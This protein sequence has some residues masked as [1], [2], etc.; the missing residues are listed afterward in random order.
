[1]KKVLIAIVILVVLI[2]AAVFLGKMFKSDGGTKVAAEEV[3]SRTIIETVTAN[4]TI[5][6]KTEVKISSEVSGE[7][8]ELLV[9]EGDSVNQGD[10]LLRINPDLS[11][12][13]VDRADAA[14]N[15]A[16]ASLASAEANLTQMKA[17]L[18]AA[19]QNFNRNKD[20]HEKGII[21]DSEFE[22]F[23]TAYLTS[24]ANVT[25]AE[26]QVASAEFNIKSAQASL[27]EAVDNLERTIIYSPI[28]GVISKLNVEEGEKVSGTALMQGTELLRVANLEEMEARVEVTENDILKVKLGDTAYIEVDAYQEKLFKGLVY[29][30]AYSPQTD[31]ALTTDQVT[32][33][34]VKI[35]LLKSSYQ[36]LIQPEY[37][38]RYP[39]RP[40]MSATAD[41]RTKVSNDVI[42]VPIQSVT[43]RIIEAY[44]DKD[45]E[46]NTDK[47]GMEIKEYV[48]IVKD[49]KAVAVE[50]ETGIQDNRFL[51]ITSGLE[52]GEKV[53]YAPY[54]AVSESLK[55]GE[56]IREVDEDMLFTETD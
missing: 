12:A 53:I 50:V 6:P 8:I 35:K 18:M 52:G 23:E 31:A 7:I 47:D 19:E 40:G 33:F 45:D 54:K 41:I 36:E 11:E 55:D 37:G 24:Q 10:L 28:G 20:L 5:Q 51:E 29:E 17:N 22:N 46:G 15:Q 49:G 43:A 56:P 39:F 34:I 1:M 9:E 14:T 4:G 26:Q 2:L 25:A 21:S 16:K 13:A 44:E 38:H 48:F 32:D 27:N 30:I 3:G 42:A